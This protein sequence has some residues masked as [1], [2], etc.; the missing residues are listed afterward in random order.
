MPFPHTS[1]GVSSRTRKA[2]EKDKDI[3]QAG[4]TA[5]RL[6]EPSRV[7]NSRV[8]PPQG[9]IS[10]YNQQNETLE[11]LPA[12]PPS[13]TTS[14]FSAPSPVLHAN[15]ISSKHTGIAQFP[16]HFY[17]P[18]ALQPYLEDDNDSEPEEAI[19]RSV[20]E[21]GK[22]LFTSKPE[23]YWPHNESESF[24]RKTLPLLDKEEIP[25]NAASCI[26][27]ASL[28]HR[29]PLVSHQQVS[30]RIFPSGQDCMAESNNSASHELLSSFSP[31]TSYVN[32][33]LLAP[34][35][36]IPYHFQSSQSGNRFGELNQMHMQPG[37][38]F[39]SY[40]YHNPMFHPTNERTS[41]GQH[42]AILGSDLIA[43]QG[44]NAEMS[45]G[46]GYPNPYP[47]IE[48]DASDLIHRIQSTIP[49]L[50]LL[51]N[52]YL[53]TS[54]QLQR[55]ENDISQMEAQA[56]ETLRQ[57]EIQ[58]DRLTK[59][60]EAASQK[61]C[62]ETS[63]LRLEIENLEENHKELHDS[64]IAGQSTTAQLEA[65]FDALKLQTE[66][67]YELKKDVL[68]QDL[69]GRMNDEAVM[70]C[71]VSD[72]GS[73]YLRDTNGLKSRW[74]QG[75]R[76]QETNQV[77]TMANLEAAFKS[78]R[79]DLEDTLR[80]EQEGHESWKKEREAL[81]R[82]FDQQR[83]ILVNEWEEER[84]SLLAFHEQKTEEVMKGR[85]LSRQ[86]EGYD[87]FEVEN[88]NLRRQIDRLK[89]DWYA[90]K[91]KHSKEANGLKAS[92]AKLDSEN[93]RL[94]KMI[95][96]FSEATDIKSRGDMYL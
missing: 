68:E 83:E 48:N 71:Q 37:P 15:Q 41:H 30:P 26:T 39:R 25:L 88:G 69:R 76:E 87:R 43:Q 89:A 63:K 62:T 23:E 58:I 66:K 55:R 20:D 17:T 14:P 9:Q 32:T 53:E 51:I 28:V 79:A 6:R 91:T 8:S 7:T 2:K 96:A 57:K 61:H 36:A 21:A 64:L 38:Y 46:A 90:D 94:Q 11:H 47:P 45:M 60:L 80:R 52:R 5:R 13:G 85:L 44:L 29:D 33:Q 18:T 10:L 93:R 74:R 49:D 72:M 77:K 78:C 75:M 1:S 56:A 65:E 40:G 54:S 4:G 22:K 12:L 82:S 27:S 70:Q 50:N 92:L 42:H 16:H 84:R 19:E 3:R 35:Y 73:E 24:E 67:K 86:Q 59:D 95:E 81:Q 34:R 31:S